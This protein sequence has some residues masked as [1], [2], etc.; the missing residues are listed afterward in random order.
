MNQERKDLRIDRIGRTFPKGYI[1]VPLYPPLYP[2][3]IILASF[4]SW[5]RNEP[6]FSFNMIL[7]IL[8]SFLSWFK[9]NFILSTFKDQPEKNKIPLLKQSFKDNTPQPPPHSSDGSE[10][11]LS[12]YIPNTE[13]NQTRSGRALI[14]ER[15]VPTKALP[16]S[17]PLPILHIPP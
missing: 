12:Q 15:K 13:P 9:T 14:G 2:I 7:I 5:F 4:L 8:V 10:P 6:I 16:R 11:L 17:S 1:I 3:L